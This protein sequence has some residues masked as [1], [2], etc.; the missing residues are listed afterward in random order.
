MQEDKIMEADR[1]IRLGQFDNAQFGEIQFDSVEDDNQHKD[2]TTEEDTSS[3]D[4]YTVLAG[5]DD[6]KVD[7]DGIVIDESDLE[8]N[9]ETVSD[10]ASFISDTGEIVVMDNSEHGDSFKLVYIDIKNIGVTQRIRKNENVESLVRSIKSTGLLNPVIVAPTETEGLYV[11][12]HGFRR[13]LA[14]ARAGKRNIPCIINTKVTTPEIPILEALYNHSK[15]YSIKEIVDYIDYLEKQK[16]IMSASMIEYL[17]QLNSGD[18][19]KLKDILNDNDDDIV[20]K[21]YDGT[22]TI[23]AAFKKL[24]QRRKKESA[25]EKDLKKA[26]KVYANTKESGVSNIEGSGEEIDGPGLTD[27]EI[28][29]LAI[30]AGDLD[31]G[32]ED[33]SLDEMVQE[34]KDIKGFGT[35]KQDVDNRERIDPALRKAVFA[36]DNY[37]C[38]CCKRG[39]GSYVDVMDFHHIIPVFLNDGLSADV[40]GD[41]MENGITLCILCHRMVHLYSTGELQIPKEKTEN[42]MSELTEDERVI[43]RDEQMKFKRIVKLGTVIRRGMEKKGIKLEQ[44]KKEHPV[45]NTG[46]HMPGYRNGINAKEAETVYQT[47]TN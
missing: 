7:D 10:D 5:D 26:E 11:L 44:F 19:T 32:L 9:V 20:S 23:D 6:D 43:Y 4:D 38:Q 37:T 35:H 46:R 25:E 29:D 17:L 21:L 12:L 15:D 8:D 27:E 13:L 40:A 28:K 3:E 34:G 18:Y 47:Q 39:G 24:E 42:D 30:S 36:R 2:D 31:D 45:G 22:Y 33:A 16:G 1:S 41:S 14:C